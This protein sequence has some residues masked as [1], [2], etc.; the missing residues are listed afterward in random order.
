MTFTPVQIRAFAWAAI[1]LG[2]V[3]LLTL[4]SPVLMPFLVA[5][6]I[7]YAM[8]PLVERLARRG[9]PRWLSAGLGVGLLMLVLLAVSLLIVPVIVQQVPMLSEQIPR[10]LD[11]L[12]K[13]GLCKRVRST[14]D[15]RVV[16][17]QLTPEGEAAMEHVP[18]VL[19]DVMNMHLS[20][21]SKAEFTALKDLLSR[22]VETGDALRDSG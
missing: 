6:V 8:H 19:A 10:L 17:V 22:M 18:E 12:E 5:M 14:E 21:F 1:A 2:T 16:M 20:G 4:L 3:L 9:W 15:R 11:R 7:A 13:K